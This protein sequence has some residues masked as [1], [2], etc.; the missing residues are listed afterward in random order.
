[1]NLVFLIKKMIKIAFYVRIFANNV[2]QCRSAQVVTPTAPI[3]LII[4]NKIVRALKNYMIP[5]SRFAKCVNIFVNNV[6]FRLIIVHFA[7]G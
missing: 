6:Q 4:L 7:P 5:A 3:E 2:R 1:M